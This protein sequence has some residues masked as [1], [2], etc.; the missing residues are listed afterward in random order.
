M[1]VLSACAMVT[2]C[3]AMV[4][5]PVRAVPVLTAAVIVAAPDALPPPLTVSQSVLLAVVHAQP[6]PVV[7]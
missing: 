3:P 1:T 2:L 5:V 4:T 7:T 6:L